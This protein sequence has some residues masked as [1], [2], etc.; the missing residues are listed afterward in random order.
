MEKACE[1]KYA[2]K[3]SNIHAYD[4]PILQEY[5]AFNTDSSDHSNSNDTKTNN[6]PIIILGPSAVGKDTMINRLK[7]KYPKII[8]K[9]SSYTTR[10]KRQ[11]QNDDYYFVTKE[12]FLEME[13]KGLLF[14]VQKY[15]DN[16]YASDLNKLQKALAD[17]SKIVILNYNI[18]TAIAVKDLY[19]FYFVAIFPPNEDA[20]RERLIKR[21]TKAEEIEPRMKQSIKEMKLMNEANFIDFRMVNDVEE[22]AFN[23]LENQLKKIYPQLP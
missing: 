14:G 4:K 6:I 23:E 2:E 12:K 10:E 18:E 11:D 3:F 15:T 9:L 19:D 22:T 13:E 17:K 5:E 20:L 7:D 8:Y 1:I 21:G 16:Y